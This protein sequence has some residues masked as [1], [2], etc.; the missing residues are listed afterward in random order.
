MVRRSSDAHR[1][2]GALFE[3][4]YERL[5]RA[6][7]AAGCVDAEDAVQEAFVQAMVHWRRVGSYEDPAG[8]VRRVA[9]RRSMNRHRGQR[10]QQAVA[11]RL[12]SEPHLAAEDEPL[13][14]RLEVAIESLPPQ[15][16][17]A[18]S[19]YYLA[20]LSV[21]EV[22]VAMDLSEGTV[23]YHLHAARTTLGTTWEP[24]RG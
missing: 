10:R 1:E 6:L 22:A 23:K 16:R 7:T 15:Q 18:V 19:L 14:E 24:D 2:L 8:W 20:K 9:L 5:V 3:R 13:S 4:E 21:A 17:T 11:D 12:G